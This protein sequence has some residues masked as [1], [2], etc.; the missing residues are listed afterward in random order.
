[1]IP[2]RILTEINALK[3]LYEMHYNQDQDIKA[4][5]GIERCIEMK[6]K[7]MDTLL[8]NQE[9]THNSIN[10]SIALNELPTELLNEILN[11]INQK[12]NKL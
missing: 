7:T 5:T 1:M 8:K 10:K 4:L 6:I 12:N 11:I 3:K 2:K 9:P